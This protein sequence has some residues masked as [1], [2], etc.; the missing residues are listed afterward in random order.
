MLTLHTMKKNRPDRPAFHVVLKD[1]S[2]KV[3]TSWALK[4]YRSIHAL[5]V[6]PPKGM[7]DLEIKMRGMCDDWYSPEIFHDRK[8]VV[9][10]YCPH[11]EYLGKSSGK[12]GLEEAFRRAL[13][14]SYPDHLGFVPNDEEVLVG[15]DSG[16]SRS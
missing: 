1:R 8:W 12:I 4:T 6:T 14:Q 11:G 2:V 10:L 13:A 16:D 3:A 5:T 7:R 15:K 9:H